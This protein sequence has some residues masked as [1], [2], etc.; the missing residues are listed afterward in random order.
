MKTI[1]KVFL[2]VLASLFGISLIVSL[3]IYLTLLSENKKS[4]N[5]KYEGIVKDKF[6]DYDNRSGLTI[7]VNNVRHTLNKSEFDY[8]KI[9]DSVWKEKNDTAFILI[10]FKANSDSSW[11]EKL[12]ID[13]LEFIK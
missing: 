6:I 3:A 10:V 13:K 1:I 7:V 11:T 8:V 2:I 9:G 5:E 4:F 12:F